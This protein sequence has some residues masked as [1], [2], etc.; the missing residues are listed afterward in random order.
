M[1]PFFN[2]VVVILRQLPPGR[3]VTYGAVAAMAGNPRAARQVARVLH[4]LAEKE[5]LPWHRVVNA[6][7]RISLR[8][9]RGRE[10]QRALLEEEGIEFDAGGTIDLRRFQWLPE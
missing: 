6:Q 8:P 9:G 4:A 10:L 3:V 7:G 2:R 5:S 1:D